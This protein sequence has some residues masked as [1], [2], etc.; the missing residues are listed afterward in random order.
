MIT[1]SLKLYYDKKE[2][3]TD[4][5]Y[6]S[7]EFS[8]GNEEICI[9]FVYTDD[10]CW[11]QNTEDPINDLDTPGRTNILNLLN[12]EIYFSKILLDP[13]GYLI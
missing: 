13:L 12:D 3:E 10:G 5:F 7:T 1:K 6:P 4:G 8:A 11:R 2:K 9:E